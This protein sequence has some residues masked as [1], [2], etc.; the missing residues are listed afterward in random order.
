MTHFSNFKKIIK[1]KKDKSCS[2]E[3]R[4]GQEIEEGQNNS[5]KKLYE[6]V[7]FKATKTTNSNDAS[8][9][10]NTNNKSTTAII[11]QSISL[12]TYVDLSIDILNNLSDKNSTPNCLLSSSSL[13]SSNDEEDDDDNNTIGKKRIEEEEE[14]KNNDIKTTTTT[15]TTT[16]TNDNSFEVTINTKSLN[17]SM[18][19][20]KTLLILLL[21]FYICWLPLIIYFLTFAS[22]KYNNLTIYILMFV[23]C[24]NSVIDPIVYAF[25]NREFYKALL[26]NFKRNN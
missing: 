11:H 20:M 26:L 12:T 13:L 3:E 5:N 1:K 8:T 10:T 16:T 6:K 15:T 9:A 21:G 2:M 22:Q 23:A 24:C 4:V 18:K 7:C 19:A 17:V 25:R 14:D